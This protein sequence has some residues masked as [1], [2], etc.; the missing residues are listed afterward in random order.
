MLHTLL[1]KAKAILM[2][3]FRQPILDLFNKEDFFQ[4]K[5]QTLRYWA[6]IINWVVTLDKTD[7]FSEYLEKVT[8]QS[9]FFSN[10]SQ[11]NK[12]RIKSFE[13]ICF[14]IFSGEMNKYNN[15]LWTLVEKISEVIKN[16]DTVHP[17]MLIL[18]LFCV[19]ILIM[20]LSPKQLND[21]FKNIWPMLLTLLI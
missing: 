7:L 13:R 15:K 17:G 2:K 10:E 5:I 14:V 3:A 16:C 12:K 9:S 21:L 11:E 19:R 8:L 1:D 4:M 20:R 6:K 18:I